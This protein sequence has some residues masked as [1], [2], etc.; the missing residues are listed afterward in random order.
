[1]KHYPMW[2][3]NKEAVEKG[4]EEGLRLSEISIPLSLEKE[5]AK[6]GEAYLR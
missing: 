3:L 5:D 2:Q 6:E 4:V 1:M